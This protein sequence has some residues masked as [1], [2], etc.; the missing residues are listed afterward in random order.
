MGAVALHRHYDIGLQF[1]KELI[2]FAESLGPDPTPDSFR[3]SA[4]VDED[5]DIDH[6][7]NTDL[8]YAKSTSSPPAA[9]S[10]A[11][12]IRALDQLKDQEGL[13]VGYY[14]V[15]HGEFRRPMW[16]V[17]VTGEKPLWSGMRVHSI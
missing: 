6:G 12:N 8:S 16:K 15:A 13:R 14:C 3:R 1:V 5:M 11:Q 2:L 4:S 10:L 17:S 9:G 7:T